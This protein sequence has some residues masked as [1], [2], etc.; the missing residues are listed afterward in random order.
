MASDV[1]ST[2]AAAGQAVGEQLDKN[3]VDF[4]QHQKKTILTL[5]DPQG[6]ESAAE[7]LTG[8]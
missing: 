3:M 6:I 5:V 8:E 4:A 1:T 2:I 7:N